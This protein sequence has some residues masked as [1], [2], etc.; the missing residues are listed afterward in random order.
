MV[1]DERWFVCPPQNVGC[2]VAFWY[3]LNICSPCKIAQQHNAMYSIE[4]EMITF[5]ELEMKN[6]VQ[7]ARVAQAPKSALL[8]AHTETICQ[9]GPNK[10][11]HN[12]QTVKL[13]IWPYSEQRHRTNISIHWKLKYILL[14]TMNN[15]GLSRNLAYVQ[16]TWSLKNRSCSCHFAQCRPKCLWLC[17]LFL[18]MCAFV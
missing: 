9:Y 5:R 17:K 3:M 13:L 2:E 7:K 10:L 12:P 18:E 11:L 4:S 8:H 16:F 6:A 14:R 1:H 15:S